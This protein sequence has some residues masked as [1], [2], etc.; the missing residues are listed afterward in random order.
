MTFIIGIVAG[1]GGVGKSTISVNLAFALKKIGF[2][3]GLIDAD[4]YGPSLCKMLKCDTLPSQSLENPE[5][6]IPAIANGIKLVS[7][8]FFVPEKEAAVIRAP[9]ANCVIHQFL[10]Q[11][12]WGDLDY[13]IIDFPPG[14]GDIQ[15][16]LMQEGKING[17]VIVTTP[18]EMALLDVR[19]AARMLQQ[20]N[21]PI[22]G[23]I[24]NM[25]HF[26]G[27]YIFGKGGGA[28]LSQELV[29]PLLGEVPLEPALCQSAEKGA[30]LFEIDEDFEAISIFYQ[31]VKK[32][33]ELKA[34]EERDVENVWLKED[35]DLYIS[36]KD[37]LEHRYSTAILQKHC[38]CVSCRSEK[39]EKEGTLALSLERIGTYAIKF[40]FSSGC[41]FGIYPFSFL[42]KLYLL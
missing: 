10:K 35:G 29:V 2:K 20:L 31:I 30:S 42:R 7:M 11:V 21:V 6:I 23:V 32:I 26:K 3:I 39:K 24:E 41:S 15:L 14:T 19:K 16:T 12:E 4:I 18:Q 34:C 37:G 28:L 38:P 27:Q 25:S 17:A 22:L 8:G 40:Q 36:W 5:K 33:I 1:K 9:I 13:L